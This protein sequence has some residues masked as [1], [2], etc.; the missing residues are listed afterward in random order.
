M[1]GCVSRGTL[2]GAG[3]EDCRP[4]DR[5]Q[6]TDFYSP[7]L[8]APHHLLDPDLART[9]DP[10]L[11]P[12]RRFHRLP[13][14]S[15]PPAFSTTHQRMAILFWPPSRNQNGSAVTRRSGW[16]RGIGGERSATTI[17]YRAECDGSGGRRGTGYLSRGRRGGGQLADGGK[18]LWNGESRRS[19]SSWRGAHACLAASRE[20]T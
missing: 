6:V 8:A 2:L 7:P 18:E 10:P 13:P 1:P 9:S 12:A 17:R 3:D 19:W 14:L 4:A 5:L 11:P 15:P 20:L 16:R